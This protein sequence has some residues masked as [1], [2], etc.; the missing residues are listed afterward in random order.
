MKKTFIVLAV[1]GMLI[2]VAGVSMAMV[3]HQPS[4]SLYTKVN[5]TGAISVDQFSNAR[6]V[7]MQTKVKMPSGTLT[8]DQDIVG[9]SR[10]GPCRV[11][12]K[13]SNDVYMNGQGIKLDNVAGKMDGTISFHQTL[14]IDESSE[15]WDELYSKQIYTKIIRCCQHR[16]VLRIGEEFQLNPTENPGQ[17]CEPD[18]CKKLVQEGSS[19]MGLPIDA[20]LHQKGKATGDYIMARQWSNIG[21]FSQSIVEQ[22][23][24]HDWLSIDQLI[25]ASPSMP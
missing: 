16:K 3:P 25:F 14:K 4:V 9:K 15:N 8:F 7:M 5:G 17:E 19:S 11:K 1:L 13:L 22:F 20:M 21:G 6:N 23:N 12:D 10:M 2:G 24:A 18:K